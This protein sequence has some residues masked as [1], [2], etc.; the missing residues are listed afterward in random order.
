MTESKIEL[1]F[2][3]R[4]RRGQLETIIYDGSWVGSSRKASGGGADA[5]D[6]WGC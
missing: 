2:P 4:E 5:V 3:T 6:A 1:Y